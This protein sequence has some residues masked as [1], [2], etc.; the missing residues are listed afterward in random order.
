M[1]MLFARRRRTEQEKSLT[2]TENLLRKEEKKVEG[3]KNIPTA[4][5]EPI[6]HIA[7]PRFRT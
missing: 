2:T 5:R 6:A 4:K 3:A 7:Q 1:G